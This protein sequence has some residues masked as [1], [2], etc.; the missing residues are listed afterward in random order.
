MAV[1]E[2]TL[3]GRARHAFEV[4]RVL[5]GL[6]RSVVVVPMAALSLIACGRPV[7]TWLAAGLLA[8]VVVVFEWRGEGFGRAARIGLW[9]GVAPF[10][11]PILVPLTGRICGTSLCSLY[12]VV[13][14]LGGVAGGAVVG[15]L[16]VRQGGD[17]RLLPA[18]GVVTL[19]AGTL[20]CLIAGLAGLA[21]LALGLGLGATPLLAPRRA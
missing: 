4:G 7:A 2:S 10:L 9:A 6:R 3:E 12:P 1:A 8:A 19:L 18:A 17:K 14:L 21:G 13:C 20:G 5:L 11:L 16:S 15:G